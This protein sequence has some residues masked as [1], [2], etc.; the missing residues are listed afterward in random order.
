MTGGDMPVTRITERFI[1]RNFVF[2]LAVALTA[3]G[4][5]DRY[6]TRTEEVRPSA[7]VEA[8]A[9]ATPSS[10]FN[11]ADPGFRDSDRQATATPAPATTTT[12]PAEFPQN[13]TD[14]DVNTAPVSEGTR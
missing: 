3:C 2:T 6:E 13:S 11:Q 14:R 8:S 1:M 9:P 7:T 5:S 10:D 12:P 4:S